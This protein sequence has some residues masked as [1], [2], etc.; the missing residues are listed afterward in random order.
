MGIAPRRGMG[1]G[2]KLSLAIAIL[3]FSIVAVSG[4]GVLLHTGVTLNE[5]WYQYQ[6]KMRYGLIPPRGSVSCFDG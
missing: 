3:H 1:I 4:V 6:E 2:L 5:A